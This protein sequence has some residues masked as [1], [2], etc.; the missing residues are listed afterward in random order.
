MPEHSGSAQTAVATSAVRA[1]AVIPARMAAVRLPGKPL[2]DL[3]GRPL[4]LWV[5]DAAVRSGL[6]ARV[7]VAT[8]TDDVADVVRAVGGE[9]V[10]TAPTHRSGTERCAEVAATWD[11]DVVVNVQGDQ[12]F[13]DEAALAAVLAPFVDGDVAELTTI[14][15]PLPPGGREDPDVVKVVVDHAGRALLFTRA[16]VPY[17]RGTSA[18][19][20]PV[21]HHLGLYGFRRE[22]LLRVASLEPTALEQAESLEQ[23]R[24]LEN[25]MPIAVRLVDAPFLEV[26]TMADYQA[27]RVLVAGSRS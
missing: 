20:L 7:V 5:H 24:A 14:A 12:P 21:H 22:A 13:V 25:G 16:P 23:L 17:E 15:C 3:G 26:N 19:P 2:L 8:D 10:M 11:G 6:F 9:V 18:L 4:V 27:A 1:L